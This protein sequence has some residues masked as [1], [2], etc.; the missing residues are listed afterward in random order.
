LYQDDPAYLPPSS[1]STESWSE[2][3]SSPPLASLPHQLVAPVSSPTAPPDITSPPV[4]QTVPSGD[5]FLYQDPLLPL[6]P[7]HGS[8]V[9]RQCTIW[10]PSDM[11]NYVDQL[12]QEQDI[13]ELTFESAAAMLVES[14]PTGEEPMT[15]LPEPMSLNGITKLPPKVQEAWIAA[16]WTEIKNLLDKETFT[17]PTEYDGEHC[18]PVP[19]RVNPF[20]VLSCLPAQDS[21]RDKVRRRTVVTCG[22]HGSS[23]AQSSCRSLSLPV[24]LTLTPSC[25]IDQRQ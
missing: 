12:M 16:F 22:S 21:S 5:E 7:R 11:S 14:F 6:P 19:L 1:Q 18:L 23:P 4:A 10:N 13:T 8:R 20:W 24:D 15:F 9:R 25:Y 17:I 3:E 2:E